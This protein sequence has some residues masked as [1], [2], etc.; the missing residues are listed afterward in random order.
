MKHYV[1][2]GVPRSGKNHTR[3][4]LNRRTGRVMHVKSKAAAQWQEMATLQLMQQHKGK[5]LPGPL[6]I[7]IAI[8]QRG[9]G[10]D[11]DGDNVES[12][13]LDTLKGLVIVDDNT[14]VIKGGCGWMP[15]VDRARPRVEIT[16]S[17]A[18]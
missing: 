7:D 13:V 16:I 9:G 5:P 8:Y 15:Y 11:C 3:P 10:N 4:F 2:E 17:E 6:R 1:V 14:R 12:L 18:A